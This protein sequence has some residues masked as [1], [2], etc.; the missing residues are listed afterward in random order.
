MNEDITSRVQLQILQRS[1]FYNY[2][3]FNAT[4]SLLPFCPSQ[5]KTSLCLHT[6][7]I[8]FYLPLLTFS[9]S[10]NILTSQT[11]K[12]DFPSAQPADESHPDNLLPVPKTHLYPSSLFS[13]SFFDILLVK[14]SPSHVSSVLSHRTD[15]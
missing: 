4:K 14:T 10:F 6:E 5:T 12:G 15:A 1:L 3:K 2:I 11:H 8:T 7:T 9:I 13:S